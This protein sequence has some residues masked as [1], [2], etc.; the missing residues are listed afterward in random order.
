MSLLC[1]N[2]QGL[3]SPLTGRNLR[4]LYNKHRP[5]LVFLMETRVKMDKVERWRRRLDFQNKVYVEPIRIGGGLAVWWNDDIQL[6]LI[7]ADKNIVHLKVVKG[8]EMDSGFLTLIYG[9]PRKQDRGSWWRRLRGLDPGEAVPWLCCGDFND[10]M[11][12]FEKEGGNTRG[13]NS[14]AEFQHFMIQCNMVDLGSKG[15]EF[16]W[17]NKR[18][19]EAHVKERLDRAV[20][21][22]AWREKHQNAQLLA[23]VE[24][25]MSCVTQREGWWTLVANLDRLSMLKP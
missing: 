22:T 13:L 8:L 11:F 12:D 1:W 6:Q 5:T 25:V 23:K 16:T 24:Q 17:S 21:N 10:L 19:N 9:P 18:V 3:G 20:C 15:M 4:F 14:L 2:C 7:K